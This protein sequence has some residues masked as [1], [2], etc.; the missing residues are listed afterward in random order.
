MGTYSCGVGSRQ[1]KASK[2]WHRDLAFRGPCRL[3]ARTH[4]PCLPGDSRP[5]G[6]AGIRP[7]QY[8]A[9]GVYIDPVCR[10]FYPSFLCSLPFSLQGRNGEARA[11]GDD[12]PRGVLC[13]VVCRA[14]STRQMRWGGCYARPG[15]S[16]PV[17]PACQGLPGAGRHTVLRA[18]PVTCCADERAQA[19]DH[20]V[21]RLAVGPAS[22]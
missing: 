17:P 19:R 4:D 21:V 15:R 7:P 16:S 2:A 5:L 11:G 22:I 9:A 8:P 10:R 20:P 3:P 14:M 1:A 13:F 18:H 12:L 6:V